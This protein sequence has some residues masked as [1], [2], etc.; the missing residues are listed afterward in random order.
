MGC[1]SDSMSEPTV[2]R[3]CGWTRGRRPSVVLGCGGGREAVAG[4]A[5]SGTG[6]RGRRV[7]TPGG[8]VSCACCLDP[9]EVQIRLRGSEV[10]R[11]GVPTLCVYRLFRSCT[12]AV[13]CQYHA[14]TVH[15]YSLARTVRG[16][17]CYL[18]VCRVSIA[19]RQETCT[20]SV[21]IQGSGSLCQI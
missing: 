14:A 8:A 1:V 11:L 5:G 3:S 7:G 6:G 20:C 10:R 18:R 17:A 2:Y 15:A 9:H 4:R 12:T 19:R 21:S 13:S 16:A